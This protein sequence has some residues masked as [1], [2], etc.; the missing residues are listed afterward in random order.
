[1]ILSF[2]LLPSYGL[3]CFLGRARKKRERGGRTSVRR[4]RAEGN[5]ERKKEEEKDD[6][7][8]YSFAGKSRLTTSQNRLRCSQ[9]LMWDRVNSIPEC[10]RTRVY[11]VRGFVCVTL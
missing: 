7:G 1:M 6:E 3:P 4:K 2:H 5:R 9:P 8:K 10:V 11:F